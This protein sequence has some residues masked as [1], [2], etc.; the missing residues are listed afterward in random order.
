[1]EEKLP[2]TT[3]WLEGIKPW[4]CLWIQHSILSTKLWQLC[5][6]HY[7]QSSSVISINLFFR[8]T[9]PLS[10]CTHRLLLTFAF[11]TNLINFCKA[12]QRLIDYPSPLNGHLHFTAMSPLSEIMMENNIVVWRHLSRP[13]S[14]CFKSISASVPLFLFSLLYFSLSYIHPHTQT[15]TQFYWLTNS[16][17][18]KFPIWTHLIMLNYQM[19][20]GKSW[21][22]GRIQDTKREINACGAP[23]VW[24]LYSSQ[25]HRNIVGIIID[26][27]QSTHWIFNQIR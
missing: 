6:D 23:D 12:S 10:K 22:I 19:N 14:F 17:K 15:S 8:M 1:M 13:L 21:K 7:P 18:K 4:L 27:L 2:K 9:F 24:H 3:P 11:S 20:P 16:F 25:D 26:P 5:F